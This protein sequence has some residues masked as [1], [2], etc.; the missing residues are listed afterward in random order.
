MLHR[1]ALRRRAAYTPGGPP[2]AP[3]HD[4]CTGSGGFKCC[5]VGFENAAGNGRKGLSF[6]L[7]RCY[8][9]DDNDPMNWTRSNCKE[10]IDGW[11]H[12]TCVVPNTGGLCC[13]HK[14]FGGDSWNQELEFSIP[15]CT[16]PEC[17]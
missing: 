9:T 12:L 6:R 11:D 8:I 4:P 2:P 5:E 3:V 13:F 10:T 17:P 14:K 15:E 1:L 7:A 16:G